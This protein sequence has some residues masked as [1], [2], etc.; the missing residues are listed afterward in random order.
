MEKDS[1][2]PEK[3]IGKKIFF[4]CQ[5]QSIQPEILEIGKII[6]H[7]KGFK[8]SW[9]YVGRYDLVKYELMNKNTETKDWLFCYQIITA[10]IEKGI[11]IDRHGLKYEIMDVE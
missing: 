1:F 8:R 3:L 10:L 4:Q 9:T 5:T 7:T 2:K 6:S 11:F